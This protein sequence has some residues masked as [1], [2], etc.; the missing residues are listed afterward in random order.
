MINFPRRYEFVPT[1]PQGHF[2]P[3]P[4]ARVNPNRPDQYQAAQSRQ[5]HGVR[6]SGPWA[7]LF[8]FL[9]MAAVL[10]FDFL[11]RRSSERSIYAEDIDGYYPF[12]SVALSGSTLQAHILSA[13]EFVAHFL[14]DISTSA[15]G[16]DPEAF[17][18]RVLGD[19]P[20][21]SPMQ[22]AL[23]QRRETVRSDGIFTSHPLLP[24]VYDLETCS[25]HI[26]LSPVLEILIRIATNAE[27]GTPHSDEVREELRVLLQGISFSENRISFSPDTASGDSIDYARFMGVLRILVVNFQNEEVVDLYR[28]A[29]NQTPFDA[30]SMDSEAGHYYAMELAIAYLEGGNDL[31]PRARVMQ[32]FD[33][34]GVERAGEATSPSLLR[35]AFTVNEMERRSLLPQRSAQFDRARN[36]LSNAREGLAELPTPVLERMRD[37]GNA[38]AAAALIRNEAPSVAVPRVS[39]APAS[40][41]P[42]SELAVEVRLDPSLAEV[43]QALDRLGGVPVEP[44]IHPTVPERRGALVEGYEIF[45]R[46]LHGV[47]GEEDADS[48]FDPFREL[49]DHRGPRRGH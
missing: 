10:P 46:G 39:L 31:V 24:Y 16:G 37:L 5:G 4:Q 29:L 36:L 6:L 34:L 21:L 40:S 35:L 22:V 23:G 13:E 26:N 8:G 7:P 42:V 3:F 9:A 47:E 19:D 15:N 25:S 1:D 12:E 18:E 38:A 14:N 45:L 2:N 48:R 30:F 41:T 17:A 11:T 49:L 20:S 33:Q 32:A 43:G 44:E 27:P 28:R